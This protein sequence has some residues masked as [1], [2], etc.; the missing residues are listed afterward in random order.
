MVAS[1]PSSSLIP[2]S[3][4]S[5][6]SHILCTIDPKNTMVAVGSILPGHPE[7]HSRSD[8]G[9]TDKRKPV[10]SDPERRRQQ[11][12]QAQRKYRE[13]LKARLNHL[14]TL[15]AS[16]TPSTC[17]SV[18][19]IPEGGPSNSTTTDDSSESAV[20]FSDLTLPTSILSASSSD[21]TLWDPA[22]SIDPSHLIYNKDTASRSHHW[23]GYVDCGCLRPHIQVSSSVPREYQEL[24]VVNVGPSLFAANPYANTLRFE[25]ICIIQAMLS[26]CLHIGITKDILCSDDA[27]SPFFRPSGETVDSSGSIIV[28]ETMQSIFKTLKPDMRPTWE[29]ITYMHP[30]FIDLLPFP[31]FRRNLIKNKG[32]VDKS[33]LYD[34][35]LNGLVCWGGAGVGRRDRDCSTGYI[36]TGTPWDSRSWEARTW[37]LQKYWALLGGDE[38]ELVRQSEWWRNMRGDETDLWLGL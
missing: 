10:R 29:Q 26:N 28:V 11:N 32:A 8:K 3:W 16:V 23:V 2:D 31:T 7:G 20:G 34:D 37:F 12:I 15:A 4:P 5:Q 9:S 33:E 24:Q 21:V 6:A 1:C 36:S 19:P 27:I 13:K 38:G 30:L 17:P 35:L 22:T 18:A 25:R 14:E